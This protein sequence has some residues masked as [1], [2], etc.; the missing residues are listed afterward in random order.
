M[1]ARLRVHWQ[2]PLS[3]IFLV[4]SVAMLTADPPLPPGPTAPVP[5]S[6]PPAPTIPPVKAPP[7]PDPNF[8]CDVLCV[9]AGAHGGFAAGGNCICY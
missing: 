1:M 9:M 2:W 5:P 4:L 7:P 8:Y 6:L 3:V